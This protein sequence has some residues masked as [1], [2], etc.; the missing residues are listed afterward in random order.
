MT[1]AAKAPLGR[2]PVRWH[3]PGITLTFVEA[4]QPIPPGHHQ[5]RMEFKYDGGGLGKGGDITLYV[6][7][8]V[9]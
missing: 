2:T 7:G 1:H 8:A 9:G 4:T 3:R 5:V 6:D